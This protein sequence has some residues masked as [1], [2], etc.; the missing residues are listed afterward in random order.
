MWYFSSLFL[1]SV[2]FSL[3]SIFVDFHFDLIYSKTFCDKKKKQMNTVVLPPNSL[4]GCSLIRSVEWGSDH[5]TPPWY[6]RDSTREI[7]DIFIAQEA[8][9]GAIH[10]LYILRIYTLSDLRFSLNFLVSFCPWSVQFFYILLFYFFLLI[11][12]EVWTCILKYQRKWLIKI[13]W[14]KRNEK[15]E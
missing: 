7:N 14:I 15:K 13:I 6:F 5:R 8:R 12:I 4:L 11:F 2:L 3:I 1:A 10:E 9:L